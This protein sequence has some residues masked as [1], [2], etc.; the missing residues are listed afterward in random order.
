MATADATLP[1]LKENL[2]ENFENDFDHP[3]PLF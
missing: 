1:P 2:L 3:H